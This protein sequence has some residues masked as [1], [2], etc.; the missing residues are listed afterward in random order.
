M[1]QTESDFSIGDVIDAL[2]IKL[3]AVDEIPAANEEPA[4]ADTEAEQET[5]AEEQI[6]NETTED[7]TEETDAAPEADAENEEEESGDETDGEEETAQAAE[8]AAVKKLAKRVDKLT[9]R[10]KSAEEQS[11]TLQAELAAARDALTRAQPI[12]VQD[13]TDPLSDV[14]SVEELDRRILSANTV[15]DNVPDLIA[16]ADME[17]EVE[18]P[19][20]DGS[21]R[22]FSKAE[23]Q[24]RLRAARQILKGEAHRRSYFAAREGFQSE[25]R[26]IYPELFENNSDARKMMMDTVRAY[27]SLAKMPNLELVIGDAIRGQALRFQQAEA[28]AKKASAKAKPA[29]PSKPASAPKVV[30]PSAAPKTKSKPDPLEALKKSGNRDAAENFVAS[31]FN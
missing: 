24:D 21:T 14:Q 28:L 9:A 1:G 29:A 5:V 8:P 20:G 18:V 2:G 30:T 6:D 10:A 25:A 22:K 26:S 3:P 27:P 19:M 13:F 23:L 12:V 31:L 15:L 7:Q 16:K 11:A 17:G 4:T